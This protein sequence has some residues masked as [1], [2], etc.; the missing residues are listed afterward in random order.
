MN[1][2]IGKEHR[3]HSEKEMFNHKD[4]FEHLQDGHGHPKAHME[5]EAYRHRM[6][7]KIGKEHKVEM[8]M[9]NDGKIATA[10]NLKPHSGV[11]GY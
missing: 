4:G 8:G 7:A 1:L 6:D 3:K 5:L 11:K 10:K 2:H 9:H